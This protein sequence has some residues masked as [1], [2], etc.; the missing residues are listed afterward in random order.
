MSTASTTSDLGTHQGTH[1]VDIQ[2]S[3]DPVLKRQDLIGVSL[4]QKNAAGPA[5]GLRGKTVHRAAEATHRT[6]GVRL[7]GSLGEAG[8]AGGLL[9]EP[10][11]R[12][13]HKR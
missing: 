10:A 3:I 7:N 12:R 2:A 4:A 9:G 1:C 8:S 5:G 13:P 6:G 11:C